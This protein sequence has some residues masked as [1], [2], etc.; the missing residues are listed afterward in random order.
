[1]TNISSKKEE[2]V[3]GRES[4]LKENNVGKKFYSSKRKV[5]TDEYFIPLKLSTVKLLLIR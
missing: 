5:C 1:M 2:I 4:F 3:I